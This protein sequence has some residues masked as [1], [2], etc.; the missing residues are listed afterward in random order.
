MPWQEPS[1]TYTEPVGWM[2]SDDT[3]ELVK[4]IDRLAGKVD[5]VASNLSSFDT[6]CT[7]VIAVSV[8]LLVAA[9]LGCDKIVY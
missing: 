9:L 1:R 4:A 8:C 5:R 3:R 7:V 2:M 6:I